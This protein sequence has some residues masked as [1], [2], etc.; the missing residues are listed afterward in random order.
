MDHGFVSERSLLRAAHRHG[1]LHVSCFQNDA[2]DVDRSAAANDDENYAGDHGRHFY[3]LSDIQRSCG[4]Y[5][6][7]QPGGDPAT[8]VAESLASSKCAGFDE[9]AERQEGVR[10]AAPTPKKNYGARTG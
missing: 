10:S 1:P 8:V 3:D 7:Q 2:D 9:S 4:V 5:S 6:D